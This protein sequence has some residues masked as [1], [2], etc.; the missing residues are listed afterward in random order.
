MRTPLL[1]SAALALVLS[2]T[3]AL[4]GQYNTKVSIGDKAP[5]FEGLPAVMGDQD[6]SLSLGDIKEDV[7][8]VAFL[9]NHCPYVV[10]VEDRMIDL[11]NAFKGRSVK[12][13]GLCVTPLPEQAPPDYQ[14][15]ARQDT[16]PM[17]KQRVKEK[18]YNYAY[19]RDDS[20]KVGRDYGAVVT[21]QLFVLDKDRV[22]RYMGLLDDNINDE[23]KV[24]KTYVKD[25]VDALL[26]G[27]EVEVKETRATGCGVNYRK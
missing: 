4:A 21:P 25:A 13:V 6:T 7:V 27:K 24:T 14:N 3:L 19:G 17:I 26:A 12:V 10:K 20:Q 2:P 15:Y 8:V 18:G 22:I 11:V 5:G 16:L 23:S 1:T 9:G